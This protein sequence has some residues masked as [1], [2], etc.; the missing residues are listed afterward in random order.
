MCAVFKSWVKSETGTCEAHIQESTF[1]CALNPQV[2][3]FGSFDLNSQILRLK[4]GC[5]AVLF[6]IEQSHFL[7]TFSRVVTV[8]NTTQT[9]VVILIIILAAQN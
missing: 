9:N 8:R 7:V 2:S 1:F 4:N 3:A 6:Q 5:F